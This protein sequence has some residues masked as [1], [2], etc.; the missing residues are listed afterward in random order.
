MTVRDINQVKTASSASSESVVLTSTVNISEMKNIQKQDRS[1]SILSTHE[2][3]IS[4][5]FPINFP[6]IM[7]VG[8]G[9]A[10]TKTLYEYLKHHPQLSGPEKEIRF[11]S[12]HYKKGLKAYLNLLPFPPING[13]VVE[14]SPDYIIV[15]EA[16]ER[17]I[18]SAT[19]LGISFSSLKFVVILRN[20]IDRAMSEYLE[21]NVQRKLHGESLL[22]R[23]EEMLV[24]KTGEL[25]INLKFIN[26]SCYAYHLR[27]WLRHFSAEQICY[28]DGDIFIKS[29]F[30]VV[31]Q[32]EFCL[33]LDPYFTAS[34]FVL[35]KKR[36]FYC[37]QD[38]GVDYPQC[39]GK[40]KGRFH[41]SIEKDVLDK[42]NL[43]FSEWDNS[44][45]TI[46]G[47]DWS[48]FNT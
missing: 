23:F 47:I 4:S 6:S 12:R 13:F 33:R 38:I 8:F 39:M 37:F 9:K 26:T 3:K 18:S 19:S 44:L 22:P 34:N 14:K 32:L 36:N 21:W 46:T 11:F 2:K 29:P 28:V 30:E 20:P 40:N 27:H 24:T 31:K 42:L 5:H 43:F 15:P 25:N 7:I 35:D 45:K 10:G 48:W 41:P 17:I 16:A 1:V